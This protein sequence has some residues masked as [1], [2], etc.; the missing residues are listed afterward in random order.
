MCV[1][2]CVCAR[3]HFGSSRFSS[4]IARGT[5][6]VPPLAVCPCSEGA[7]SATVWGGVAKSSG[8]TGKGKRSGA[9]GKGKGS[10]E[11]GCGPKEAGSGG[12]AA[13]NQEATINKLTAK[14][15]DEREAGAK[16]FWTCGN[17]GDS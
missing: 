2:V 7:A 14:A 5:V 9:G 1:C 13:G 4:K 16:K 6:E 12:A 15:L 17:C 3:S 8:K 11:A 10:R